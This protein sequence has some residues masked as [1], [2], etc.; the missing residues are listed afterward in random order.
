MTTFQ[1]EDEDLETLWDVD[2][3]PSE[4]LQTNREILSQ[5]VKKKYLK[6]KIS[7]RVV[8][9]ALDAIKLRARKD[10]IPYQ[11]MINLILVQHTQ[12]KLSPLSLI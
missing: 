11:T 5:S 7:L 10:G 9:Y 3:L 12:K 4:D 1:Q 2:L 8:N 6:Q